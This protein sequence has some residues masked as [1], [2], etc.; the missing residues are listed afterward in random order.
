M[1]A[2]TMGAHDGDF[3]RQDGAMPVPAC[4]KLFAIDEL[5]AKFLATPPH[6][7]GAANSE[8][9]ERVV[10]DLIIPRLA[11]TTLSDIVAGRE[12]PE[13][14][15]PTMLDT[16]PP[17]TGPAADAADPAGVEAI[18]AMALA[19]LA[20][21]SDVI[22]TA[23]HAAAARLS[24]P[25]RAIDEV[26]VPAARRLDDL[27]G[28][29]ECDFLA[30]TLAAG[31][32]SRALHRFETECGAGHE[33]VAPADAPT[34]LLAPAPGETHTL[35]LQLAASGL[36][37]GGWHVVCDAGLSLPELLT[38]VRRVKPEVIGLSVASHD[39]VRTLP[40]VIAALRRMGP[41]APRAIFLGGQAVD[42]DPELA[43]RVGA[44]PYQPA[45]AFQRA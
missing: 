27:W 8:R 9:V 7:I 18:H 14:V 35:G 45:S 31:T 10:F 36:T 22:V 40:H 15:T 19:A 33:A 24:D 42:C 25:Q 1:N 11:E 29:D 5:M 17:M 21:R 44:D 2:F 3:T 38:V 23:L 37:R 13:K 34:L 16:T 43:H 6:E 32:L 39:V 30:V 41:G 20:G 28:R 26:F 4:F 12:H